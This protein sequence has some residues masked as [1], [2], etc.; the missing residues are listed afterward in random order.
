MF[1][2]EI[3][4]DEF[5]GDDEEIK[6]DNDLSHTTKMTFTPV[7]V[8]SSWM[9]SETLTERVTVSILLPS[10]VVKGDFAINVVN[11]GTQLEISVVWPGC[12]SNPR[13]MHRKWLR[14]GQMKSYHPVIEGFDTVLR[15]SRTRVTDSF[16]SVCLIELPKTVQSHIH[17]K[18]NLQFEDLGNARM[19]YVH[20]KAD[21]SKYAQKND[22]DDFE[23][24]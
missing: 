21:T 9:E 13:T 6:E 2:L 11:G 7:H 4:D 1:S 17:E 20:L 18:Y 24:A 15:Q 10:G 8:I 23:A 14:N 5:I 22:I 19:V 12:L 16:T 3:S